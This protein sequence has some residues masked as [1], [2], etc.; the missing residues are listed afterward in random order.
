MFKQLV[1]VFRAYAESIGL[2]DFI[3]N[4]I[5][6]LLLSTALLC[7]FIFKIYKSIAWL[8]LFSNQKKLK[9]DL[10]PYNYALSDVR[11]ATKYYISTRYQNVSPAEDEEPGR[12]YIASAKN[13]LIPLFLEEV[14]PLSKG[15]NKY[16]LIL[17]DTGMGKTTFLINLYLAYKAIFNW[18]FSM[19]KFDIKLYPV[20]HPNTYADIAAIPDKANTILLLDAFDEDVQAVE[21]YKKRLSELLSVVSRFRIVVLTCR[22][23][24]FPSQKEEPHETGYFTGGEKGEY[25][26]Q[27]LYLST[28]SMKDI[29]NYLKKRYSRIFEF[30][31]FRKAQRIISACPNLMVRPMLLY[32]IDDLVEIEKELPY[33]YQIY[34]ELINQWIR[35][36]CT[37]YST[38]K[39]YKEQMLFGEQ[40][41]HFSQKL[42]INF[43]ENRAA[44]NGYF[45]PANTDFEAGVLRMS[46]LEHEK[47][48][49]ARDAKSKSLLNRNAAGDYKFSHK[50]ILEYFLAQ[51]M[52]QNPRFFKH[53][54]FHGM[55]AAKRFLAEMVI[56]K[57]KDLRG[58]YFIG[59][60]KK[61][62]SSLNIE[63][64]E[65]VDELSCEAISFSPLYFLVFSKLTGLTYKN[66]HVNL[67]VE[68]H[69]TVFWM[70]TK[71]MLALA[72]VG[73]LNIYNKSDFN[74]ILYTDA[75]RN[76]TNDLISKL[77]RIRKAML[78]FEYLLKFLREKDVESLQ[79][80]L[81]FS[82][83][84]SS[85]FGP[86]MSLVTA[87]D[88][89]VE[90]LQINNHERVKKCLPDILITIGDL[91][92]WLKVI[93]GGGDCTTQIVNH[94]SPYPR[95]TTIA[96]MERRMRNGLEKE[97]DYLAILER[98][99]PEIDKLEPFFSRLEQ[100]ALKRPHCT[101]RFDWFVTPA[102]I[103]RATKSIAV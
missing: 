4:D 95:V 87:I 90:L 48:F 22:T 43:Y 35:R 34:E 97:P 84:V 44:R 3:K 73:D 75:E 92:D 88:E 11:R 56:H 80:R 81:G 16:Y 77:S 32:Y 93:L 13:K 37:K 45:L 63:V 38:W 19:P 100:F 57:M 85:S 49:D 26:F 50:S 21:D 5:I 67:F 42:A 61:E 9:R 60:K 64:V 62:F 28:F 36:E 86:M 83:S 51:E 69:H 24:F 72:N 2:P 53:F 103:K 47:L 74:P 27:K 23:Q 71:A 58:H 39:K 29:N 59:D 31:T 94:K 65:Q 8:I 76:Y 98:L 68:L 25:L 79:D 17:A 78:P 33:A 30:E 70:T 96:E 14:F 55:D 54:E 15:D 6:L 7:T 1:E 12:N 10:A 40:L 41:K 66:Y 102:E 89:C 20:W 82:K 101:I 52:F 18:P 99:L 91:N 46:E